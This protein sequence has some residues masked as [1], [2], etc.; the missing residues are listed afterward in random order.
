MTVLSRRDDSC[1]RHIILQLAEICHE[2]CNSHCWSHVTCCSSSSRCQYSRHYRHGPVGDDVGAQK[3]TSMCHC[4]KV[5]DDCKV[6]VMVIEKCRRLRYAAMWEQLYCRAAVGSCMKAMR[7][8]YSARTCG[9]GCPAGLLISRESISWWLT[10]TSIT[11]DRDKKASC[12]H[13]LVRAGVVSSL[14][15]DGRIEEMCTCILLAPRRHK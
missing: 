13:A 2:L 4:V 12:G 8:L 11:T 1:G 14:H 6:Q 15:E 5:K 9:L 10:G 7:H 3:L